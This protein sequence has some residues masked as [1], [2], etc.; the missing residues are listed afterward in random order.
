M[1]LPIRLRRPT[2]LVALLGTAMLA[3]GLFLPAYSSASQDGTAIEGLPARAE[4]RARRSEERATQAEE[5]A[6]RRAEEKAARRQEREARRAARAQERRARHSAREVSGSSPRDA[7]SNGAPSESAGGAPGDEPSASNQRPCHLAVAPASRITRGE[8]VTVIGKLVCPSGVSAAEVPV[9]LYRHEP[10]RALALLGTATTAADGSFQLK[11]AAFD[12]NGILY[13]RTPQARDARTVV[14]VAPQVTLTATSQASVASGHSRPGVRARAT[15]TGSVSPADAGA[16]VTLQIAYVESAERWRSV[17]FGRVEPDGSYSIAHAFRTPG[18]AKVRSIVQAGGLNMAAGISEPLPYDVAQPQNP[19]LTIQTAADPI[20]YGQSVTIS[21]VAAGA[22]GQPIT[23][24]AR[25]RG[26]AFAA[27]ATVTTDASGHYSFTQEPLARTHYRVTDAT[28][29]STVL[30]ESVGFA[31]A[32]GA[33]PNAVQAGQQQTFSGTLAPAHLG[34]AVY[35][36]REYASGIGF[37]VIDVGTVDAASEYTI[38]DSFAA[39]GRGIM[40]IKVPTDG[41]RDGTT[42]PPFT[43]TVTP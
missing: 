38:V 32:A 18:E 26:N 16:L 3:F 6:T 17:A 8:T 40:R 42:S 31:L 13:F 5:R 10:A 2:V 36:E 1:S 43:V 4:E 41:E 9:T 22:D 11:P 30:F 21:G 24:L 7:S 37:Y 20:S 28:A 19:R 12:T 29:Q 23:L 35:L 34:E 39:P 15:F 14:R 25:A 33:T 27:V